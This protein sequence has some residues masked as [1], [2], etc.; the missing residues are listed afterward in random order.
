MMLACLTGAKP[1]SAG[2]PIWVADVLMLLRHSGDTIDWERLCDQARRINHVMRLRDALSYVR[3]VADAPIPEDVL[4]ELER[5]RVARRAALSYRLTSRTSGVFGGFPETVGEY[6]RLT[7][8]KSLA[9]ALLAFPR[10]LQHR[11][12]VRTFRGLIITFVVKAL[13]RRSRGSEVADQRQ[14]SAFPRGS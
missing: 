7:S 6:L 12:G 14:L 10:H 3:R 8:H 11:F 2:R 5:T 9:R 1:A 4:A 13:R